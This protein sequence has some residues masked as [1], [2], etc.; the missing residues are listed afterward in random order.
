MMTHA[1][2]PS[3]LGSRDQEDCGMRSAWA[4]SSK[5][6]H[7]NQWLGVVGCMCAIPSCSG[8]HK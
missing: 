2:N 5:D 4:K 6:P 7:L 8:K 1:C 3:Y